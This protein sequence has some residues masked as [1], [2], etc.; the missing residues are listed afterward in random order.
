MLKSI[1]FQVK[2]NC[3][4][5]FGNSGPHSCLLLGFTKGTVNLVIPGQC[6]LLKKTLETVLLRKKAFDDQIGSAAIWAPVYIRTLK[7]LQKCN[8]WCFSQSQ[9]QEMPAPQDAVWTE[10]TWQR[11]CCLLTQ[12]LQWIQ[13]SISFLISESSFYYF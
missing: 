7:E 13:M 8:P 1:P 9:I 2:D 10:S 12:L 6:V 3:F 4:W 5:C 11:R